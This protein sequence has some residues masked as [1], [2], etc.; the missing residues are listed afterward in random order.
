MKSTAG[1][2]SSQHIG[3]PISLDQGSSTIAGTL[4]SV[5]HTADLIDDQQLCHSSDRWIV[6][7]PHVIVTVIP[8]AEV[9]ATPGTEIEIGE[10]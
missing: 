10:P 1:A 5:S 2:L 6:G 8:H 4:A 7:R 9:Q 3:L